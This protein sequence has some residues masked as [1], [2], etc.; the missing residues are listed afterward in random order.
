MKITVFGTG[1]VGL[2]T[3]VCFAE[4]GNDVV[5]IDIDA[6]KVRKLKDGISPIFEPGLDELLRANLSAGRLAFSTDAVWGVSE[7][8]VIFIAVGTPSDVDGSAD[9]SYV[10]KVAEKIGQSMESYKV[11]VNKSTVPVGS[12]KKVEA[13]VGSALRA[14]GKTLEFDVVSNPEFLREGVAVEDCLKPA[15]VV[16]GTNSARAEKALRRLY[17]PFLKNGNPLLV[18]DP[19]SSEMTKYAANAMLAARIS[20]MNE[21]SRACEHWGADIENVR[22]GIGSDPRIGSQFIFAGV[23][24]GGSCFPKDVRALIQMGAA[25]G[26]DFPILRAVENVNLSQRQRFCERILRQIPGGVQGKRVGIWGVAFKPGTDDI[27]EAPALDVMKELLKAGAYLQVFDS[28]AAA[29]AQGYFSEWMQK[30]KISSSYLQFFPNQYEAAV[31]AEALVIITEWKSF[32]EPN[33]KK[34]KD[35]MKGR[36][37]FDGRNLYRRDELEEMGFSYIS[38]GRPD[39]VV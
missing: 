32:R 34:L 19:A 22:R 31:G 12:V 6:E 4:M 37:I 9:L 3:A 25:T 18:M 11:I 1:Y 14:R 5:G 10:L 7:G 27:R 36:H 38:I 13:A 17:E 21:F 30:E 26:E 24:Y 29:N 35:S 23:G 20:I 8:D 39:T 33:W 15:R 2:V 16:V 28:V